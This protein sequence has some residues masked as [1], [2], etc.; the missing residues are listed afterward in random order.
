MTK[1]GYILRGRPKFCSS[2]G[3][4]LIEL[5]EPYSFNKRTGKVSVERVSMRCPDVR[6][7]QDG[8]TIFWTKNEHDYYPW[9]R[10]VEAQNE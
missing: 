10:K 1:L 4:Q 9:F 5:V 6:W 7:T 3:K 8:I 2:C